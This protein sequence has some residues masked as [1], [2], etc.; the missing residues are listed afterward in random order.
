MPTAVGSYTFTI[1]AADSVVQKAS[2]AFTVAIVLALSITTTS[3]PSGTVGVAY[4][5][6]LSAT[7]GS[8][9]YTWSLTTGSLPP[10]LALSTSGTVSGMPTAVGSYTFTI[11]AADSVG[12]KASQAFTVSIVLALSI[13]T[14]SLPNGAVG[15]AYSTTLSATGGTPPY[16]WSP[17]AGSLPPGLALST[18]GSVS[19]MPTAVG[20]YS[21]TIQASDSAGQKASQAFAVSVGSP[22]QLSASPTNLSFGNVTVGSIGTQTITLTNISNS[23]VTI[24]QISASG[25]G[26][27][28][29]GLTPP[30]TLGAGQS[31]TFN[32]IFSPA[33]SGS[34]TG[35]VT[36][37]SNATRSEERRVGKECRSRWS[38]DT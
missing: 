26:F 37:V 13:T 11:Q 36:V 1:Q 33:T 28:T 10:G 34:L 20:S 2:Q 21:F 22:P 12:Q 5:T 27:T 14:T 18:S 6:T 24:S 8:P 35:S 38:P 19:G 29:I 9:P 7:G 17:T 32:V 30:L 16:T 15:V 3:L 4:S 25:V 31:T 23:S